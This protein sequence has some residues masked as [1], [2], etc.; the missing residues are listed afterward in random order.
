MNRVN[1]TREMLLRVIADLVI[2]QISLL[3]AMLAR[4]IWFI[5]VK[6]ARTG[7]EYSGML[8]AYLVQFADYGWLASLICIGVFSLSGFYTRGRAYNSRYKAVV[9][10]QAVLVAYTL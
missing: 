8:G 4:L 3:A 7:A 1:I 5:A 9:I 6:D 10:S 2:T